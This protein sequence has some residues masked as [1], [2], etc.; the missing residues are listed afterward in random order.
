MR[1][2]RRVCRSSVLHAGRRLRDQC[3]QMGDRGQNEGERARRRSC[4]ANTKLEIFHLSL[5]IISFARQ[6]MFQSQH[7]QGL[8]RRRVSREFRSWRAVG[9]CA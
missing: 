9:A 4:D 2:V 5:A 1:R 7:V 3:N 6:L 8:Q